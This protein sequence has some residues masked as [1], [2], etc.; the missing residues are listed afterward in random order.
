[1]RVKNIA[2]LLLSSASAWAFTAGG[3]VPNNLRTGVRIALEPGQD[4]SHCQGAPACLASCADVVAVVQVVQ[5]SSTL[6]T[7][8]A[9][10]LCTL[11][12]PSGVSLPIAPP[13]GSGT[14]TAGT[15]GGSSS[16]S[17]PANRAAA[18]GPSGGSSPPLVNLPPGATSGQQPT[19]GGTN[20]GASAG[21]GEVNG[22][23]GDP[24]S[25]AQGNGGQ[26]TNGGQPSIGTQPSNG[27]G[28]DNNP[29]Q[30]PPKGGGQG[31]NGGQPGS[32]NSGSPPT[33]TTPTTITRPPSTTTSN[34][35]NATPPDWGFLELPGS[36]TTPTALP[37]PPANCVAKTE[38]VAK[39]GICSQCPPGMTAFATRSYA[40]V[41]CQTWTDVLKTYYPGQTTT[42][43]SGFPAGSSF[44]EKCKVS[45]VQL[46][47]YDCVEGC[48]DCGWCWP[49]NVPFTTIDPTTDI[50]T[51]TDTSS[52]TITNTDTPTDTNTNTNTS[53]TITDTN[54][55]TNTSPTITN[56]DINTN[57]SPTIT[58]TNTNT[59]PI[60]TSPS[61]LTD[62]ST[63][64]ATSISSPTSI[65]PIAARAILKRQSQPTSQSITLTNLTCPQ[66]LPLLQ[67]TTQNYIFFGITT[68]GTNNACSFSLSD[69]CQGLIPATS[70]NIA[71]AFGD[72]SNNMTVRN[73]VGGTQCT[74]LFGVQNVPGVVVLGPGTE[75]GGASSSAGTERRVGWVL[76]GAL[77]GGLMA[78]VGNIW[79][80]I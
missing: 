39:G 70:Q 73:S 42:V 74:A 54:T 1:M 49:T 12:Q 61:T 4:C 76:V 45:N 30:Q 77:A 13:S 24:Q 27:G 53:P 50:D 17:G 40:Y 10:V 52:P 56:T 71:L 46:R 15:S 21:S 26:T 8:Q 58:D 3:R 2:G 43:T 68:T 57:T 72:V 18:G 33:P 63:K 59:S 75:E 79:I 38:Y 34:L 69:A 41:A 5:Y 31:P 60:I 44:D 29:G 19:A 20:G 28:S 6:G 25:P 9:N 11:K 32:N 67:N 47:K 55:D 16:Q 36:C 7:A 23:Q 62:T 65:P 78:I 48:G 14:D 80:L 51:P 66:L 22:P 35:V 64:T 37:T